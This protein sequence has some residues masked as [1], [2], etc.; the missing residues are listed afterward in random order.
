MTRTS[1]SLTK[2]AP[3]K[4]PGSHAA[5]ASADGARR[6]SK[7]ARQ[8]KNHASSSRIN[9]RGYCRTYKKQYN[10]DCHL[11]CDS[12]RQRTPP[13]KPRPRAP[14]KPRRARLR[15]TQTLQ[16]W[17]ATTNPTPSMAHTPKQQ[18]NMA[19]HMQK[20]PLMARAMHAL[21][22]TRSS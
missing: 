2:S 8:R 1:A 18:I 19:L 14:R 22:K 7:T 15:E 21:T 13:R 20:T 11:H 10:K 17:Q 16:E 5:P 4:L 12:K 3:E 9:S 6:I